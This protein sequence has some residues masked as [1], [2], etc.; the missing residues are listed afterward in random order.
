MLIE[1]K[2]KL[3]RNAIEY[4]AKR[5]ANSLTIQ[6]WNR[7]INILKE[8]AN[9]N[10]AYLEQLHRVFV[11]NYD[12]NTTGVIEI[13]RILDAGFLTGIFEAIEKAGGGGTWLGSTSPEDENKL[14]FEIEEE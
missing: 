2:P 5:A 13:P 9:A 12:A 7:I 3:I 11:H 8:Q 14:W 10:T 6:D 4:Q 1:K